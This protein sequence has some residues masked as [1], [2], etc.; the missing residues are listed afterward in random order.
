MF[1]LWG[2]LGLGIAGLIFGYVQDTEDPWTWIF[3]LVGAGFFGCG[4]IGLMLGKRKMGTK[5]AIYGVIGGVVGGYLTGG[6]DYEFWLQM[7]IIGLVFGAV[8]GILIGGMDK[9]EKNDKKS[10]GGRDL[11]CDE[12]KG[13]VGKDDKYCPNCGIEFE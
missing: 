2:A 11:R 7:A 3:G 5:F 12:C 13:M 6:S 9:G 10:N 4:A 1:A 8:L